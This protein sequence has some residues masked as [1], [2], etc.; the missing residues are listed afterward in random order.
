MMS[1]KCI[2]D[3]SVKICLCT[4]VLALYGWV[5][6]CQS[7]AAD[8]AD[9]VEI[10]D[11]GRINWSK[12]L[13]L[14]RGMAAPPAKT[15]VKSPQ[16]LEEALANAR[17]LALAN[18]QGIVLQTRVD[19]LNLVRDIASSTDVMM[20]KVESLVKGAKAVRQEYLSDG[21]VEVTMQMPI[22][23]GFAQLVLPEEIKQIETIKAVSNEKGTSENVLQGSP[24]DIEAE[25]YTGVVVDARG[26]QFAPSMAPVIVDEKSREVY[27][28]AFVSREFAVQQGISGYSRDMQAARQTPRVSGNPLMVKGLG[29][30]ENR[31]ST[32]MISNADASKIKSVSEHI[33]FLKKCRVMIV[34]D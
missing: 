11:H 16:A 5:L 15:Q 4:A 29:T 24:S 8:K 2:Y 13:L 32:I 22:Y 19:S 1:T 25:T 28:P 12:G 20:A 3:V 10:F 23:G 17:A 27:G 14:S 31:V 26:T 33:S 34:V 30:A 21:T 18:M 7:L 6:H 9:L